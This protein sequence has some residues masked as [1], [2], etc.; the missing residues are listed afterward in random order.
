MRRADRRAGAAG[1]DGQRART[2]ELPDLGGAEHSGVGAGVVDLARD[3]VDLVG[4][5]PAAA[6]RKR[7]RRRPV[8][9][10]GL[11]LRKLAVDVQRDRL[12]GGV[13]DAGEVIPHARLRDDRAGRDRPERGVGVIGQARE[14][15]LMTVAA[16]LQEEAA[17]LA[18]VLA[19]E[20]LI[21]V[22]VREVDPRRHAEALGRVDHRSRGRRELRSARER[23]RVRADEPGP[24]RCAACQREVVTASGGVRRGR[25]RPLVERPMADQSRPGC[26]RG[27]G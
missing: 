18:P 17:D 26:D 4:V 16:Q 6:D 3:E 25:A 24:E 8:R 12:L 15:E 13:V 10:E 11:R 22:R 27:R 2:R 5:E 1:I 20:R 23:Q 21:S 7:P 19:D 14:R 9:H